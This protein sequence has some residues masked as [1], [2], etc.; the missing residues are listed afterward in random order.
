MESR[1]A[2]L[3]T[4]TRP[5][6]SRYKD[7]VAF[8]KDMLQ[9]RKKTERGF[10]IH[11]A[12]K[13]LRKISPTLVSLMLQKKRN[14]TLD[15]AD[16]FAR[17]LGLTAPEK[18]YFR[19]WIEKLE[20]RSQ[21]IQS[22][23]PSLAP[24]NRKDVTTNILNDWINVYVKDFFQIPAIQK[25]PD[26]IDLQLLHVA[27]PARIKKAIQFLIREGHLRKTLDG[28][29]VI[30][31]DLAV[32]D[33]K[34]PSSKIRK[35]HKGAL[36]LAKLAIDL[37]P[38]SERIANSLIIPMNDKKYGELQALIQE[39]AEKLQDFAATKSEA[40][41]RLYQILFNLSPVGGKIE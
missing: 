37:Y 40:G 24:K 38:P 36:T 16:D 32:A 5:N 21:G 2:V 31:V 25:N 17:L 14:I 23:A 27:T 13:G 33:P 1:Q 20:N 41:N 10:S 4:L 7:P 26:L 12:V 6:I 3:Q 19:N 11:L 35:F 15:R 9:Y 28:S 39:F 8:V 18:F 30:D 34:V 29:Y 22:E